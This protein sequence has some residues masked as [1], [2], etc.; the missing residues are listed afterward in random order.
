VIFVLGQYNPPVPA[1]PSDLDAFLAS[2]S[3]MGLTWSVCAFGLEEHACLLEA[4]R[5]GGNVRIGFENNIHT[6]EGKLLPSNA[7]S[8][9]ALLDTAC[10]E[11]L[12]SACPAA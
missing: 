2:T 11:G 10:R 3:G 8:V 1:Q 7:A 12:V 9:R 6:P 5:L 4:I